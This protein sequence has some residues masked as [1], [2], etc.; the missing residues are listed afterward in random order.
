M[1]KRP[2]ILKEPT[3]GIHPIWVL[4]VSLFWAKGV[5]CVLF[6]QVSFRT[7]SP[8]FSSGILERHLQREGILLVIVVLHTV[9][10][11]NAFS[12]ARARTLSLCTPNKIH[13]F[14]HT[15]TYKTNNQMCARTHTQ[16]RIHTHSL[17]H[18][19]SM[20]LSLSHTHTYAHALSLSHTHIHIQTHANAHTHTGVDA[21]A[22]KAKKNEKAMFSKM[23]A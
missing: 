2:I 5:L 3:S 23:F 14:T 16:R 4:F 15:H 6:L 21:A 20:S 19:L 17:S 9:K 10:L 22:S 8:V 12:L 18:S 11:R 13:T 1:Q 7:L